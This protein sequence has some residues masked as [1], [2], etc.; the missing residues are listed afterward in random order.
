MGTATSKKVYLQWL[1][2]LVV[3]LIIWLIPVNESFTGEIRLFLVITSFVILMMAFE[4]FNLLLP[5]ML[6]PALY[7]LSGLV[8]VNVGY[9]G[10]INTI[11]F[12]VIGAL[13]LT[14]VLSEIGLLKRI[15]FWCILKCGG[16]FKGT[17]WGVF[18]AG[19]V[20]SILTSGQA[21]F[22]MPAFC[23]GIMKALNLGKTKESAMLMIA[24]AL[25]TV[26]TSNVIYKPAYMGLI[27]N[28]GQQIVPDLSATWLGYSFQMLPNLLFCAMMLQIAFI[29]FK[30][31]T[32]ANGKEYFQKEYNALG[33]VTTAEKKALTVTLL[34]LVFL[35]TGSLHKIDLNFG[36]IL[37]PWLLYA[38]GINVGTADCV[39]RINFEMIFFMGSCLCIGVVSVHLGLGQLISETIT[40]LLAGLP[41]VSVVGLVWLLGFLVNLLMTPIAAMAAFS[42]PLTQIAVDLGVNPLVLLYT[43]LAS[44]DQIILPYEY[45]AYIIFYAF[46]MCSLNH[47]FKFMATKSVC[48]LIFTLVIMVPYWYLIGLV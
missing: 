12:L 5:S 38:P 16:S 40:P 24:G 17:I 39:K 27:L 31:Q 36:F 25:S 29:M 42:A 43:F 7:V 23:F 20:L 18:F 46:G 48:H 22:I 41:V 4:F 2:T 35:M 47:F 3:P 28:G 11:P 33:A 30:P 14:E 44:L 32:T 45:A 9:G 37:I 19:L 21:N 6:L 13:L 26:S 8:P 15:A 1:I 10:Y 34:L